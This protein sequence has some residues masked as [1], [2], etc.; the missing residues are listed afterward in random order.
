MLK[1]DN[2]IFGVLVAAIFPIIA[3]IIAY[4]LRTNIY[5]INRPAFPYLISIAVNLILMRTSFKYERQQTGKGMM[6]TTF[7]CMVAIFFLKIHPIA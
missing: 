1:K 5:I 6:L 7:I 2:F 3:C 4:A